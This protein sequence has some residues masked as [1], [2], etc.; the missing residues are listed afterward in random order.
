M[1]ERSTNGVD[2]SGIGDLYPNTTS[3]NDTGRDANTTYYY[4]IYSYNVNGESV[5]ASASATTPGVPVPLGP[6]GL[7]VIAVDSYTINLEWTDNSDNE[8]FFQIQRSSTGIEGSFSVID[9]V[10]ANVVFYQDSGL[11]AK[12]FNYYR[13]YAFNDSGNSTTYASGWVQTPDTIPTA[14]S[15]LAASTTSSS[16]INLTWTDNSN[17]ESGF[18]VERS[19]NGVDT[20]TAVHT[21]SSQATSYSNIGLNYNTIYYYRIRAYN[22][23]GNSS[24]TSVVYA[25]TN[26]AAPA[27][28]SGAVLTV[29][30][31]TSIR[32][33]WTDES[34]NETG[35]KVQISTNGT[36]YTLKTTTG[37]NAVSFTDTGLVELTLYYYRVYAY[38]SVGDSAPSNA[39]YDT[40]DAPPVPADPTN[41]ITT[42]TTSSYISL[43]W[44]DNSSNETGFKLDHS[45]DGINNWAN[46]TTTGAGV[47]VY[48]DTAL[49]PATTFYYRVC[50]YNLGGD[51]GY[52]SLT[53]VTLAVPDNLD[54]SVQPVNTQAGSTMAEVKVRVRDASNNLVPIDGVSI[55]LTPNKGSLNGTVTRTT[56]AGVA[57]FNDLGMTLADSGYTLSAASSGLTGATSAS[58]YI[59]H[60][61]ANN[62]AWTLHPVN[63]QAGN[64]MSAFTIRVRDVYSK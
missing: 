48:S 30:S 55:G 15:G 46:I 22:T 9:T 51:S 6:S 38:N 14:P 32:I 41:L 59:S 18:K 26:Q 7:S 12:S 3:Y 10:S 8:T 17:N 43:Q 53:A 27:A 23:A 57:T 61:A 36:T 45:P 19:P 58:F 13:I 33:D 5:K 25:T 60:A 42:T 52:A 21:T 20:W 37:V 39:V 47:T 31:D 11:S 35:F 24:Y 50:A 28:P 2:Y 4:R 40:T 1:L 64:T 29:L 34:D 16:A 49:T 54:F 56:A 44:T 63:T 62:L